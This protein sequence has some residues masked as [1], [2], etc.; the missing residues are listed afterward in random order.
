MI[1]LIQIPMTRLQI[2]WLNDYNIAIRA[3]VGA[4]MQAQGLQ[5]GYEWL[6]T[7]TEPMVRNRDNAAAFVA[8]A[9]LASLISTLVTGFFMSYALY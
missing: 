7:K 9:Y 8:P 5:D 6:L 2:N 3:Q 4:E 1:I